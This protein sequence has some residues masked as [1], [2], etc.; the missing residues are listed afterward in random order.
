MVVLSQAKGFEFSD[1]FLLK[2]AFIVVVLFTWMWSLESK[3][4]LIAKNENEIIT[5]NRRTDEMVENITAFPLDLDGLSQFS[6]IA[7]TV[8]F[9][10]LLQSIPYEHREM[11]K[12][13]ASGCFYFF[14]ICCKSPTLFP[15]LLFVK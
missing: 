3:T 10:P 9:F 4:F 5:T 14:V 6:S 12:V 7:N 11:T 15:L 13:T 8:P 1:I 2:R